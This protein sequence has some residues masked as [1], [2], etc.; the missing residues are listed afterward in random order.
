MY[1]N[2]NL[3]ADSFKPA[4]QLSINNERLFTLAKVVKI[5]SGK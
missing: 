2:E 1:L 3:V 5:R 4:E